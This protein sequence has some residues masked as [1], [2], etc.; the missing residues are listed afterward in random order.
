MGPNYG[1][2]SIFGP[3]RHELSNQLHTQ[4]SLAAN[5]SGSRP[6]ASRLCRQPVYTAIPCTVTYSTQ[7][8]QLR[9]EMG[10]KAIFKFFYKNNHKL[11][12]S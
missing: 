7:K 8:L 6:S 11:S 5:N 2:D 10:T 1:A 12:P 3:A 9:L 4:S